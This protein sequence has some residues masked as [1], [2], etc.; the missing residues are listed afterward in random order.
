MQNQIV[1]TLCLL[2]VVV[3]CEQ[4]ARTESE[5]GPQATATTG[6]PA[7][8]DTT[9]HWAVFVEEAAAALGTFND[10]RVWEDAMP[11]GGWAPVNGKFVPVTVNDATPTTYRHGMRSD[12]PMVLPTQIESNTGGDGQAN[13]YTVVGRQPGSNP[14]VQWTFLVRQYSM[15]EITDPSLASSPDMAVIGH[16]PRTGATA[17]WQY[18]D[19]GVEKPSKIVVSPFSE[20]G[21]EFWAEIS[22]LRKL[23]CQRCHTADAFIHTPWID[24]VRVDTVSWEGYAQPMVPSNPLGPFFFVNADKGDY[25]ESWE[26][27]LK[28]LD[29]PQN[30]C[31]ECHRVSPF[32]MLGLNS[33]A[34]RYAGMQLG[35]ELS[36]AVSSDGWQTDQYH[37]LPWMPPVVLQDFYAGQ[38]VQDQTWNQDYLSA[39]SEINQLERQY[40]L[41][42]IEQK[43]PSLPI[44]PN[45]VSVPRP[46][47]QYESIMVDRP[48]Q[49]T[50][51]AQ[52]SLV[53]LDSRMRANTDGDLEQWRFYAKGAEESGV[54]AAPMVLR[55]KPSDGSTIELDV[56]FVGDARGQDSSN[57]W[58]PVNS[59]EML[60]EV[61]LGDYFG[62]VIT[63][64]GDSVASAFIPYTEDEWATITGPD[65]T[66]LFPYGYV[67]Y[68]A[69]SANVPEPGA[70]LTFD[71]SPAY[72]T[73]SFELQNKL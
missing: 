17:Y 19:N 63:N 71:N 2:V 27:N 67:T 70:T 9:D 25:F 57:S 66:T 39:A 1:W 65:G 31:T 46:D 49:D 43:P 73:Y 32:S 23:A 62:L 40:S 52:Q 5:A 34:T 69:T 38:T 20:G 26:S 6:A 8:S 18:F 44:H 30:A 12:R 28:H 22:E 21:R 35:S 55:R 58:V 13:P 47:R 48:E 42:M 11:A 10:I 64:T 45:V 7:E 61:K 4:G 16:H 41:W 68:S 24:Q 15:K 50:I 36:T 37:K 14:E 33:Y 29:D 54:R 59:D 56:I 3:G 60:Q 72:R 51:D 53:I